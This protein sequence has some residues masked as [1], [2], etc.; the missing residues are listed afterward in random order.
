MTYDKALESWEKEARLSSTPIEKLRSWIRIGSQVNKK[1]LE[2]AQ[3][4]TLMME[5]RV[6]NNA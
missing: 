1:E 6:F 2:E 4:F 5:E 3:E